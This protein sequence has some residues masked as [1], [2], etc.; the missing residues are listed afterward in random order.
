MKHTRTQV[1]NNLKFHGKIQ[2]IIKYIFVH[3]IKTYTR[4]RDYCIESDSF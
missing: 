3:N 1:E 4:I 2:M